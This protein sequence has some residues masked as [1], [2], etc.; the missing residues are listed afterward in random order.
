MFEALTRSQKVGALFLI[1]V[2]GLVLRLGGLERVG[3]N[4]DE[5][6]KVEAARAY[7]HGDFVT[8]LEHPMLMK[9]LIA[10]SLAGVGSWNRGLGRFHQLSD[11]FAVRLPN[12]IFGALTAVVIY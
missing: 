9:S 2:L 6:H 7:L 3:F 8:N 12:A 5:V 1:V 11:E 10:I 4:E